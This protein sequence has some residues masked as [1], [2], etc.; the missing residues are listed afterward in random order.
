MTTNAVQIGSGGSGGLP[1]TLA[2]SGGPDGALQLLD[3][4][5]LPRRVEMRTCAT[6]ED[7]WHAIR[8]LCV[9]GAPAIGVAA[10]YGL[11]LGTRPARQQH[12][13]DF[14]TELRKVCAYLETARP[15]AINLAWA[16]RR[17]RKVAEGHPS[18]SARELWDV[19]LAEAHELFRED[20]ETCRRIGEVG[21]HLIPE[22]GGVLTHCNAGALATVAYGTALSLMYVAHEQGRRFRVYA[23][24]TRPLLQ[25]A[26]LTAFELSAAG[27]D[28]TVLCDGAAASLMSRGAVQ[29]VVVGAD[30]IAANGD[31]ANKIGTLGLALAAQYHD[32]PFYVAAPRSTFDLSLP[33]GSAIPVEERPE[34]EVRGGFGV[35]MVAA[36]ARCYNPAFDVTPAELI[37]GIITEVG[38]LEPVTIEKVR[39]IF[40]GG[41]CKRS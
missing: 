10:A 15:T 34:A 38:L 7:V 13:E 8:E 4:T 29:L 21:A 25:G 32:I 30:R 37:T 1:P 12:R 28:V 2:W 14:L 20:A 23:D 31:T 22:G 5:L 6:A 35:D 26:R 19:M 18:G 36:G 3:Q 16:L 24:E 27:I 9:R 40:R 33:D 39:E 11:C 17:V 41:V